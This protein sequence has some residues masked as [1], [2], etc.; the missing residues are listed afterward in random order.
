MYCF[1]IFHAVFFPCYRI[2][3]AFSG[4]HRLFKL[5][6]FLLVISLVIICDWSW[7]DSLNLVFERLCFPP[8]LQHHHSV[9][10]YELNCLFLAC[11]KRG[12]INVVSYEM[13]V[14][15]LK[16]VSPVQTLIFLLPPPPLPSQEHHIH[17]PLLSINPVTTACLLPHTT[18]TTE[19]Q[20]CDIVFSLSIIVN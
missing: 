1:V 2:Y 12:Q 4:K 16:V 9:I 18:P 7:S 17:Q 20:W 13:T 19:L 6:M 3:Y 15:L 11:W 10:F 5:I 8:S 14:E